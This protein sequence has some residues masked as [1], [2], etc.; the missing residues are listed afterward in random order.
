[1]VR[2]P[3]GMRSKNYRIGEYCLPFSCGLYMLPRLFFTANV[4][5]PRF[6]AA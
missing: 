6:K 1:M 3:L 2:H 4:I 5:F